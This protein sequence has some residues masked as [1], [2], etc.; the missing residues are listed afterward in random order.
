MIGFGKPIFL[1]L[2]LPWIA[3]IAYF[4]LKQKRS[5]ITITDNVSSR[6]ISSITNYK[7]LFLPAHVFVL[8]LMGSVLIL[9]A[10]GP[11]ITGEVAKEVKT[12]NIIIVI[13]ASFS[14][15]ALDTNNIEG[16]KNSEDRLEEA[17]NIADEIVKKLPEYRFGLITYSGIAAY[18]S[19]PTRDLTAIHNYLGNLELHSFQKTGSNFKA[20]LGGVIHLVEQSKW[21]GFQVVMISDGEEKNSDDYMDELEILKKKKI[22]VH[23]V[24]VGTEEGGVIVIYDPEELLQGVTK[25][26]AI[27]EVT[28]KR[29]EKY[30]E[31]ISGKTDGFYLAVEE[32]ANIEKLMDAILKRTAEGV[33]VKKPGK[34]D[35]S[36]LFIAFFALFFL[37]DVLFFDSLKFWKKMLFPVICLFVF[38]FIGCNN[39]VWKAH[40]MNEDGISGYRDKNFY[41]ARGFFEKSIGYEVAEHIPTYNLANNYFAEGNFSLSH[42]YYEEAL[43]IKDDLPEAVYN[44]GHALYAWGLKE[45]DKD[46]CK[47]ERTVTLWQKAVGRF[48]EVSDITVQSNSL[49]KMSVGNIS[50][51]QTQ[52]EFVKQ[53][54]IENR[55]KCKSKS[56]KSPDKKDKEQKK[57][58]DKSG[59]KKE[60]KPSKGDDPDEGKDSKSPLTFDQKLQIKEALKR[61]KKDAGQN[62]FKQ[63]KPQQ[64]RKGKGRQNVGEEI[65]W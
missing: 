35:I 42:Q 26:K 55:E 53:K 32:E 56:S 58:Q 64:L 22:P 61:I 11:Q 31:E 6:F 39:S 13:D 49:N 47:I 1:I 33:I 48:Q 3:F 50:F 29:E 59:N 23:T 14:M 28:T 52:I 37:L 5:L 45:L 44:D 30:L 10:S 9:S 8:F 24:G 46:F 57:E 20:A 43:K 12:G 2:F 62:K 19:P 38:F 63:T 21:Q 36:H 41:E 18:H 60:Q 40:S 25:P 4:F 17:C 15:V 65:N 16:L 27:K 34:E 7:K 54:H 51:I